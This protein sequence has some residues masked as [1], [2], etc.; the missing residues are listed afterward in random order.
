MNETV[1]CH[2]AGMFSGNHDDLTRGN[3]FDREIKGLMFDFHRVFNRSARVSPFV[4][5]GAGLLDQHRPDPDF[6]LRHQDK[7]IVRSSWACGALADLANIGPTKLQLKGTLAARTSIG[8]GII[9][10]VATLGVQVVF[11]SGSK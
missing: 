5:I 4:L 7:E 1:G 8:R 3:N 6:P 2:A 11:G 10:M 9:D